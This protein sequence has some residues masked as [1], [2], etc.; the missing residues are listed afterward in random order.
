MSKFWPP[1]RARRP[2]FKVSE[3]RSVL[4]QVQ[5]SG[6]L[7][8]EEKPQAG[9]PH[10]VADTRNRSGMTEAAFVENATEIRSMEMAILV[11]KELAGEHE[12]RNLFYFGQRNHQREIDALL[13]CG[14]NFLAVLAPFLDVFLGQ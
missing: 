7:L 9:I 3:N 13:H 4:T 14:T 12:R 2:R 1:R 5:A 6:N 8:Q 10:R 11:D